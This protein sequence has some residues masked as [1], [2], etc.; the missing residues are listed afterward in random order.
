MLVC[1]DGMLWRRGESRAVVRFVITLGA[2]RF[3]IG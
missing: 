3:I 1:Q 2:I